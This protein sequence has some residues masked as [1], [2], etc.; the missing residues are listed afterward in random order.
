MS[1]IQSTWKSRPVAAK[2]AKIGLVITFFASESDLLKCILFILSTSVGPG[3]MYKIVA[4]ARVAL[5]NATVV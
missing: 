4:H 2:S 1:Q 5:T 3:R